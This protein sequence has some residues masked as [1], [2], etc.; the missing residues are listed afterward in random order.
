M[1]AT[2]SSLPTTPSH[3]SVRRAAAKSWT[4]CRLKTIQFACAASVAALLVAGTAQAVTVSSSFKSGA[5]WTGFANGVPDL[6]STDHLNSLSNPFTVGTGSAGHPAGCALDNSGLAVLKNGVGSTVNNQT[7]LVA[8]GAGVFVR[9]KI[10]LQGSVFV[11]E[12]NSYGMVT[13]DGTRNYQKYDLYGSDNSV[14]PAIDGDP[15]ANGWTL[16]ANVDVTQGSN[17]TDY[18]S[19]VRISGINRSF[20]YLLWHAVNGGTANNSPHYVELDTV[21][22]TAITVGSSSLI[23]TLHYSDTFTETVYGGIANR[24]DGTYPVPAGG[25][26]VENN[27]GN[28]AQTW[29]SGAWSINTDAS[30]NTGGAPYVGSGAGT[31]TGMTQTGGPGVD[32]GIEYG[33]ADQFVVQF[34]A[35][36]VPDRVDITASSA[37]NTIGGGL[38]V[39]IRTNNAAAEIALYNGS[40][41]INSGLKSGIPSANAWHNYA[42]R[43]DNV[44]KYLEVFIDETSRGIVNLATLNGGSH[45]TISKT[46]VNVGGT[47]TSS[48]FWSDNFQV[49]SPAPVSPGKTVV[50]STDVM[51]NAGAPA[52]F[53]DGSRNT[54]G[55]EIIRGVSFP[56]PAAV[57]YTSTNAGPTIDLSSYNPGGGVPWLAADSYNRQFLSG[58]SVL[59]APGDGETT[60]AN[61]G[62]IGFG[63]HGPWLV[64]FDLNVIRASRLGDSTLPLKLTG[65]FAKEGATLDGCQGIIFVDGQPVFTSGLKT[66]ST[67]SDPINVLVASSNRWLTCVI[68]G[69]ADGNGWDDGTFRDM[70]LTTQRP[71]TTTLAS[72]PNPS[73]EGNNVTFT[74]TIQTNGVMAIGVTGS[75]VFMDSGIPISTNAVSSGQATFITSALA[76]G[77]H[78]ITAAY[79]GDTTNAP[80]STSAPLSQVVQALTQVPT[81]TAL[82]A[83]PN[84]SVVGG[85]VTFTA[86]VQTNGTTAGDAAGAVVFLNGVTPLVT[87]LVSGGVAT[88]STSGL[89]F[90]MHDITA[91][92]SGTPAYAPSVSV[93]LTQF[94]RMPTTT[95]LVPSANPSVAGSNVTFTATVQTNGAMAIGA[96]GSMVFLDGAI[97]LVTNVVSG[98]VATLTTSALIAGSHTLTAEYSGDALY[99]PST[100][101]PPLT[102]VVNLAPNVFVTSPTNG[103]IFGLSATFDFTANASDPD[104]SISLVELYVG[105]SRV[106]TSATVP[107]TATVSIP[108]AGTWILTAAATDDR[109]AR[110]VS[111]PVT[112]TIT[113]TGPSIPVSDGLQ[114]WLTADSGFTT[115]ANGVVTG[116]ADQTTNLNHAAQATSTNAPLFVATAV[117]GRP[118]LRFD[119]T[120]GYMQIA[121]NASLQP[122]MGD[123][124]VF[125]VAKRGTGSQGDWPQVIGSRPWTTGQDVGWAVAYTRAGVLGSH[126]TD[127]TNGHDLWVAPAASSLSTNTFQLWQVEE[128]RT[129]GTTAFYVNGGLDR[130]V[131]A[132]MPTNAVNQTNA[133]YIG[134]EIGGSNTRRANMDLAEVLIYNRVLLPAEREAVASYLD[135]KY[136]FNKL[137]AVAVSE[138]TNGATLATSTTFDFTADASDPDGSI[139]LIELYVGASRVAT[140]ATVPFTA[141]V[142]IPYAGTY[143]LTAAATDNRGDRVVSAPVIITVTNTGPSLPI[144]AGLRLWLAAD[145]SFTTNA[146][147][148]VTN[149]ADQSTNLN[150]AAQVTGALAPLFVPNALNG[151]P[152]LHFDGSDDFLQI[153]NSAS[154][155]PGTGDWT[156]FVVA[157]RGTGSLGDYPQ[158]IG[159][160]PWN[161]GF[162]KGWAVSFNS[163]GFLGSHYADGTTGHDMFDALAATNLSQTSFQLW[164][165]EE[166]RTGGATAYYLNGAPN[167]VITSGMPVGTIDQVNPVFIGRDILG[168]NSRKANMDLAEVLIYNR[169][170][171]TAERA[172]VANYLSA[173]YAL[174]FTANLPPSVA[175]TNP[176]NGA[177]FAAPATFD[178]S[179]EASDPD[180]SISQ[181]E[182]YVGG[183]RVA[184]A[185]QPPFTVPVNILSPGTFTLTAAAIDNLGERVVSAPVTITFTGG[186]PPPLT[187]NTDLRLWLSADNS[188]YVATNLDGTVSDW[189]DQSGNGND[190]WQHTAWLEPLFV[191]NAVNGLPALRFDGVT[192]YLELANAASLQ[193]GTGDW[194]V[195]FVAKRGTASQG[196][197]PQIIGS[198]PWNAPYDK[199]WS[200]AFGGSGIVS[201]HFADGS[202]G[203]DVNRDGM[204]VGAA[205]STTAFQVW[206]VEEKRSAGRTAF[207]SDGVLDRSLAPPMPAGAIDQTNAIYIGRDVDGG[208]SRRAN[209]DLAEVLIYGRAL[210]A[211]ERESV[212][213]YLNTKYGLPYVVPQNTPPSV[214][215]TAPA[216]GDIFVVP[217]NISLTASVSDTGGS[218]VSVQ[219]FHGGTLLGTV[220]NAPYI[221]AVSNGTPGIVTYTAVA[222]DNLGASTVSAAVTIT[223][224]ILITGS[225][226]LE[227][228]VGLSR[229]G[230]GSRTVTFSVTDG[231]TTN[232][233]EQTLT[234]AGGK[235]SYT[236]AV[237][238]NATNITAKTAWSLRKALPVPTGG[239]TV[240]VNFT[241]ANLLLAGDLNNSNSVGIEDYYQLA[242][243][244]YTTGSASD[245]D[246]SGL[247]DLDDYFLLSNRWGQT[248]DPE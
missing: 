27:Y 175:V 164:H 184:T 58:V 98:G 12:F 60:A 1:T 177:T 173:K 127:G 181:V 104:G 128:N 31:T 155:Q 43:F 110:I 55:L 243:A 125:V 158:I 167:R 139:S 29:S 129:G 191:P 69:G 237:P 216:N 38:S 199:G 115:N 94:V 19:G 140:S 180:G 82:A 195:F 66:V 142:S 221:L 35:F 192:N 238:M 245:L 26:A 64:T 203:H 50:L 108:Y 160:R 16:I 80:S 99:L 185:T 235:G 95:A 57:P 23:G 70:K 190:A 215:I 4:F 72:L 52:S 47:A 201:S 113:N 133:I 65:R 217:T 150:N 200:V 46:A 112:I 146:S 222:T 135:A 105:A 231:I 77:P 42:V 234:L 18:T 220:T 106:A 88:F 109:G 227:G 159:S 30:V 230:N 111:A 84:P 33:I 186:G 130:V 170:L 71:T 81:T 73:I 169:V 119:G 218:I 233:I 49:G 162:D 228:Y 209:M 56:N 103:A 223:N 63:G 244:W 54:I 25:L 176:A 89:S 183:T 79:G 247:V 224:A 232:R 229:D 172:A 211:T 37:R 78:T 21:V 212:T 53:T 194:T 13:S 17:A 74:A 136:V 147:G 41:E 208:N 116:W 210:N 62:G 154:L 198:R 45:N 24:P 202:T 157:K 28:T 205:L 59:Y 145:T 61:N 76:V 44:N 9:L 39:F 8:D 179:A 171:P 32:Y 204:G 3:P 156:V 123:W 117:N 132:A 118:A 152:V 149:W 226:E 240:Q 214:A 168:S 141:P 107:F 153:A 85:N 166:N 148:V 197:W 51:L 151:K 91:Q 143:T 236:L 22:R 97:P 5:T 20:R 219:F 15:L 48:R 75:V 134:R 101:V 193:P 102:Q 120:N 122:G 86:T 96:G 246:G 121:N 165:V 92:Y 124:T 131:S 225:V 100:N 126:Y 163:A 10:D 68:A 83:V 90:G 114:L 213:L 14:A 182:F 87:N 189:G 241:G 242:A 207:Y 138:P 248:G 7:L 161:A 187:V 36:Q 34:D 11:K 93:T 188:D 196:D 2:K 6:S 174:G 67:P 239:G 137:P 144:S 40:A 178:L 206:Q